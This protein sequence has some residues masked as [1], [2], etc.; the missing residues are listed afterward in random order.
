MY[1]HTFVLECGFA[2]SNA[3]FTYLIQRK[4]WEKICK[5]PPQGIAPIVCEFHSNLPY[6]DGSTVYDRGKWVKF[7]TTTI[8]RAYG[9]KNNDSEAYKDLFRSLDYDLFLLSLKKWM[10]PWKRNPQIG[11]VT[12]FPKAILKPIPKAWFFFLYSRLMLSLHVSIVHRVKATLLYVIVQDIRF[13]LGFVIE[14]S[15][16]KALQNRS[17]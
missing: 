14:N 9:M 3:Y 7:N 13:D 8:N 4:G 6:K 16:L 1:N 12:I 15:I 17:T 10:K 11:E 2:T 5:H